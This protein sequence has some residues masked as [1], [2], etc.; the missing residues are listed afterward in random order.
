MN[1]G[2][3]KRAFDRLFK[4][5]LYRPYHKVLEQVAAREDVWM[6]SQG[7]YVTWWRNRSHASLRIAVYENT[8]TACTDVEGAVLEAHPGEFLTSNQVACENCSFSGDVQW[9]IDETLERKHLLVDALQREG[10]MNVSE[11]VESAFL[12]SHELDE[13]LERMEAHLRGGDLGAYDQDILEVREVVVARLAERGLPLVRIWYH[14]R[15]D[16]RTIKAVFSTRYDVDRAIAN[17]PKILKLEHQ[18][19]MAS[20]LHVRVQ[21]PFYA[22]AEVTRIVARHKPAEIALHAEFARHARLYGG[23]RAA[24]QATKAH[25][26]EVLGRPV[27]GVSVHGGELMFNRQNAWAH[28]E[29]CGFLY[30]VNGPAPYWHPYRRLTEEGQL[31]RTYYLRAQFSDIFLERVPFRRFRAAFVERALQTLDQAAAHGGAFVLLMHPCYFGLLSYLLDV[32]SLVRFLKFL[33]TYLGT[34]L[35][36]KRNQQNINVPEEGRPAADVP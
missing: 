23:E 32:K 1:L 27:L 5:R 13:L 15:V 35:R 4:I 24:G 20:T 18:F 29:Q 6:A 2:V 9:V 7:E 22:D 33:P 28:I 17:M 10:I 21:H 16:D 19:G 14:P 31:E 30:G 3:L 26:E 11:G 36:L 25:L 8:M 12:L 34:V